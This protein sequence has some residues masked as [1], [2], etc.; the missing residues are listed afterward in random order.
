MFYVI[1]PT[2]ELRNALL[3][4]LQKEDI[5]GVFHYVPLHSSPMGREVGRCHGQMGVTKEMSERLLR[6][7]FL[8]EITADEQSRVASSIR[9]FLQVAD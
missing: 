8:Y 9:D 2:G 1:M 4:H 5:Q 6:L 7:P 3:D